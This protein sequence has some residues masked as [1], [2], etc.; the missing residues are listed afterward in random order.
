MPFKSQNYAVQEKTMTVFNI[1]KSF[2]E[3]NGEGLSGKE[4]FLI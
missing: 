2:G 4:V 3:S 1:L